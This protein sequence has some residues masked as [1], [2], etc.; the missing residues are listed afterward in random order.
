[1]TVDHES[2]R[3]SDDL[4]DIIEM[5]SDSLEFGEIEA[6][7]G[8]GNKTFKMLAYSGGKLS[9]RG[10]AYPVVVSLDG[11]SISGGGIPALRDHDLSKI[12]GHSTN[13][14]KNP[15]LLVEGIVS[16]ENE[17]AREVIE[18]AVN[19]F[20]WK[21]SIGASPD[22]MEFIDRGTSANVF[23]VREGCGVVN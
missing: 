21:V 5:I 15:K 22:E 23:G 13:I 19:G 10:W 20:R 3:A 16:A 11:M 2:I 7:G 14:T 12:V 17:H 18:S 6:E 8:S 1:M 4:P 9:L